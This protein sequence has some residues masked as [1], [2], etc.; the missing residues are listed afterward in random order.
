MT[1]EIRQPVWPPR[2]VVELD[3]EPTSM[4]IE[5]LAVFEEQGADAS[6]DYDVAVLRQAGRRLSRKENCM[7][8]LRE[9]QREH[10]VLEEEAEELRAEL[11]KLRKPSTENA[12]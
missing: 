6:D 1:D 12:A 9:L 8:E 3:K 7:H 5:R 11:G 10:A 2:S 4:T